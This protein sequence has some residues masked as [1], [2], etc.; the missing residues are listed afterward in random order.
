VLL[1]KWSVSRNSFRTAG[2]SISS[3]TLN[4]VLCS[5][6]A[7]RTTTIQRITLYPLQVETIMCILTVKSSLAAA[8]AAETAEEV[9]TQQQQHLQQQTDLFHLLAI[10][11]RSSSSPSSS[12]SSP[13]SSSPDDVGGVWEVRQEKPHPGAYLHVSRQDWRDY[14]M[15]GIHLEAYVLDNQIKSKEGVVALHCENEWPLE[16]RKEFIPQITERIRG[17]LEG[18]SCY[19]EYGTWKLMGHVSKGR[20][21]NVC[22][23]RVPFGV[24]PDD[25]TMERIERQLRRLM[26]LSADI[27]D[28]IVSC[29]HADVVEQENFNLVLTKEQVRK[30]DGLDGRP[31]WTVIDGYVTDCTEFAKFHPGGLRKIL[32]TDEK[33]TGTGEEFGFSLSRGSNAHFPKTGRVFQEGIRRF[34]K[35]QSKVEVHFGKDGGGAITILGKLLP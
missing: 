1:K 19:R 22:E 13:S 12:S 5:M 7:L 15:N 3:D 30:N 27:D 33:R 6:A 17:R 4:H 16:F 10:R 25:E 14:N 11:L 26:T 20:M 34:D 23:V 24:S 9:T 2:W 18:W 21:M 31:L 35:L 28:V 29:L 8:A 32:E